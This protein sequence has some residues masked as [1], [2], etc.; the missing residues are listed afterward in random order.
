MSELVLAPQSVSYTRD[1]TSLWEK[2]KTSTERLQ[3]KKGNAQSQSR[4]A[5][6]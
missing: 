6:G 2:Y 5:L 3:I 4:M 1:V